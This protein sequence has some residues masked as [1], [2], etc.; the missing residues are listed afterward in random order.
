MA[1]FTG[2]GADETITPTTVS[3]TVTASGGTLPSD[4]ADTI[5][6][7]GGNDIINGGGGDDNIDAGA[8]D[9][10]LAG[11]TGFDQLSGGTGNDTYVIDEAGDVLSEAGGGGTDTVQSAV[12]WTLASG[13]ERLT[14][15]G[16][17]SINAIGNS[18][19][20]ILLGNSAA[21]RLDGRFGSD[22]MTGGAGNDTYIVDNAGDVVTE[23]SNSG[24]DTVESSV[25]YTLGLYL[26]NLRLSGVGATNGAGNAGH[27]SIVGNSAANILSGL[28]G[29]DTLDGRGGADAMS[30]GIGNDAYV[31]DNAGDTVTEASGQGTDSVRSSVSY[32]LS[33]SVENL[34]LLSGAGNGTG[35]TLSNVIAG[36]GGANVLDGGAG[37][38]SLSGG[39]GNDTYVIDNVGDLVA[40][41]SG[42]GTD[43]VRSSISYTLGSNVENLTLLTGANNGTG[44]G[45]ANT[46]TG[47][48]AANALAGADGNDKL[49]GAADS[50]TLSGGIGLD[51]LF[52]GDG[53]DALS[54]GTGADGFYFDTAL[55]ENNNFDNIGDFVVADDTI[56]L[57]RSI[58]GGIGANGT[59]ALG[60][61]RAGTT[62][63]DADD[64]I[65]YDQSSGNIFY[66]ADGNGAGAAIFFASV[67]DGTELTNLDFSAYTG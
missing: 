30:G 16:T 63:M 25:S 12:T 62:A 15:T 18:A 3:P 54:G 45:G 21:N 46:I 43:T 27:N 6:G 31:V 48:A 41:A 66:D 2:T 29:N 67:M 50:D 22:T 7:G 55:D 57:D 64:R 8:G 61:F 35:N 28:G 40:E 47:N 14:L 10:T 39:L 11:G 19:A 5:N 13:F 60:A 37:A 56:F 34:T 65:L 33:A 1:I 9:D 24:A 58:F 23:F 17:A 51:A 42:G 52:G 36:N 49:S 53:N 20:N 26:E 44:N 32:T 38:D 59:L 4:E